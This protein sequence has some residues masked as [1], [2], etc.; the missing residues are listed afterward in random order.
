[1]GGTATRLAT[2]SI[3]TPLRGEG[4]A[5]SDC[6]D[7]CAEAEVFDCHCPSSLVMARSSAA[8]IDKFV[9]NPVRVGANCENS[10]PERVLG[11][12]ISNGMAH[13]GLQITHLP[14]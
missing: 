12:G 10:R 13:G 5:E 2:G 14:K 11:A 4:G 9:A 6:G 7:W 8:D 1:M 3:E